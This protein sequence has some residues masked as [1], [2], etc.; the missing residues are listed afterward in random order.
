MVKKSSPLNNLVESL[1]ERA[2]ELNCLYTIEEILQKPDLAI[3]QALQGVVE[4]I[5]PGMQY[6][7]L[8]QVRLLYDTL[9]VTTPNFKESPWFLKTNIT[10]QNE[11]LGEIG[12]FYS[13]DMPV[14]DEGP[15]LKEERRLLESIEKRLEHY[16][17]YQRLKEIYSKWEHTKQ[18]ISRKK[19]A[20]W[21]VVVELI[22]RTDPDIFIRIARR[23]LNHLI[24]KGVEEAEPLLQQFVPFLRYGSRADVIDPNIPL[25]K[26]PI[27][28]PDLLAKKAFKL[29]SQHLSNQEILYY[30]QKWIQQDKT[31]FL[32]RSTSNYNTS[33]PEIM[34]AIRRYYQINPDGIE[35]APNAEIGVRAGLARRFFS[36]QIEFIN[37]AKRYM[38]IRDFHDLVQH[39]ISPPGSHGLL[40]GKS[41]GVFL[42]Y[43]ILRKS[44]L[45]QEIIQ[46]LRVPNTW[47]IT[48]D[49]MIQFIHFNNLEYL[50]EQKYKN[51][52][53][54]S[55]EY[56]HV[57]QTFKN[58]HFPP[59]IV[60]GLSMALDDFGTKPLIVRSSSILED[61]SGASFTGK[62][63]SLFLANQGTKNERLEALMDAIAEVFASTIG[64]DPIQYRSERGLIDFHEEMGIMI[65]EVVGKQIG[66]YFFPAFA[67]VAFSNNDFRWSPRIRREDGLLRLVPGLG[68][69]AVDRLGDDY[70]VLIAPGQPG[71]RASQ[72]IED[73]LRYCPQ[74]IDV[75]NLDLNSFETIEL[76]KL[77]RDYGDEYPIIEKLISIVDHDHLRRPISIQID[78]SKEDAIVTFDG[79]INDSIFI[80]Q[81]NIFLKTLQ[82]S[83]ATPVDIEFA[84]DGD[85]FYLLQCR[86]QSY[87]KYDAPALIPDKIESERIIFTANRYISNGTLPNISFVVYVDPMQY[88]SLNNLNDLSAVGKAIGRLNAL[89]PKRSFILI[90]PGRWGSRGDIKLGVNVTYSDINNT[91]ALVEIA[92]EKGT[93]KPELSFG[94]HFFQDLIESSIKYIPLYPDE[95]GTIFNDKLF[96]KSKNIFPELVPE[97]AHLQ[98]AI[99]VV[100][101]EKR[102]PGMTME[103][104]MNAE[105]EKAVALLIPITESTISQ[106]EIASETEIRGQE[107]WKWRLYMAEMLAKQL[108]ADHFGVK[109]IY[110]AGSSGNTTAQAGSDIDLIIHFEGRPAK[111]KELIAW[112]EG[113]SLCLDEF[114][115]IRTGFKAGGLLDIHFV[116]QK[117]LKDPILLKEKLN[118]NLEG[119]K[120][121]TM[122]SIKKS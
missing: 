21:Q 86:P 82:N 23:M 10:I 89:L 110:L 41:S 106:L 18:D 119:M 98:D 48:S 115:F 73:Y 122:K 8:S 39:I 104:L 96:N 2:K 55:K 72:S 116:S 36:D 37:I 9:T 13:E 74:K 51:T 26:R 120:K 92:Q 35:L 93:Y 85:D 33:L 91:A 46:N 50:M 54:I 88:D 15:F 102:F 113:W 1:E 38:E 94:T 3:N 47:Y 28:R 77:L 5:P 107:H 65:Q 24:W 108:D 66:P 114:N 45:P 70:P 62:Y 79:L 121:L 64:P 6:P 100:E 4:A 7:D 43:R 11:H 69:R 52:N 68:T 71:L 34:E 78:F 75:L 17:I 40:G 56:P 103:I 109:D 99:K 90:G 67:G 81:I 42:A 83:L 95:E 14:L 76:K 12:I 59:E 44:N 27:D 87:S 30:I 63:K 57:V 58:S 25:K 49:T 84:S 60:Q 118:I 105:T 53:E 61:R 111:K 101:I 22:S 97:F 80:K 32:I 29:A 19:S 117:E 20:E 16:L 31:G 112:L